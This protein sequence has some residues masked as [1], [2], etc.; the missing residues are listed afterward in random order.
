MYHQNINCCHKSVGTHLEVCPRSEA[1]AD[2]SALPFDGE[3]LNFWKKKYAELNI[4]WVFWCIVAHGPL[5]DAGQDVG[6]IRL[7]NKAILR[8]QDI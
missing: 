2:K 8:M 6:G 3:I 4:C 7:Q 1:K 5:A